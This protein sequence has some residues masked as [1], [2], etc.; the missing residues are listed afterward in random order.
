MKTEISLQAAI[1][2]VRTWDVS[3]QTKKER[4]EALKSL[5]ARATQIG[6]YI[7]HILWDAEDGYPPHACGFIQHT[8]RPY[9]QG[10]GCDGTTDQNI[11]LIA[12]T[13][14]ER[15]DIDYAQAYV[16]AYGQDSTLEYAQAWITR[17]RA[18]EN[19]KNETIVPA[20]V[21]DDVLRLM[22]SDLYQINNRSLV[23]VLSEKLMVIGRDVDDWWQKENQLRELARA[24]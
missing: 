10:Y 23:D 13:L 2:D 15:L 6:G 9:R 19:L 21:S 20:D 4:I 12:M 1:R 7:Q 5:D 11:H 3:P 24:A 17:S 18:D 14:C 8:L 16:D 22:L